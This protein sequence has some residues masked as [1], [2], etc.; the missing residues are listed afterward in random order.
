[1]KKIY[2]FTTDI[3]VKAGIERITI[4]LANWFI[5]QGYEVTI[6]SNFK[7]GNESAYVADK[8]I[9]FE[10]LTNKNFSGKP[11]STKRLILF[12]QNLVLIKKYFSKINNSIIILQAFPNAFMYWLC[13]KQLSNQLYVVEHVKYYYY[14]KIIRLI[15]LYIYRRIKNV[16]VLTKEDFNCYA[17][18][19]INV[20]MIPNGIELPDSRDDYE[21]EKIICS[22]GRLENQ[23]RFDVLI[24]IFSKIHKKY[25]DWKLE[26]YGKG[27]LYYELQNQINNL[28]LQDSCF[29]MGTTNDVNSVLKKNSIFVVSS[30]YEGFS[31]VLIEAMSNGIACV[32]FDCPTGPGEIITDNYDGLLIEN[33]NQNK[34]LEQICYLIDNPEKRM[35]LANNALKS[36]K[37]FSIENIGKQWENLFSKE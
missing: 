26:I 30:E 23:K 11:G 3:T 21:R 13:S 29:L 24:N 1:M 20:H 33:Q 6:V 7:T 8:K 10:F 28:N 35:V 5:Q 15:R 31:I 19:K 9:K 34:M 32:S 16:V 37:R 27:S 14:N 36:V 18:H 17:K 22:I 25:P 12:L 4:N 2:F